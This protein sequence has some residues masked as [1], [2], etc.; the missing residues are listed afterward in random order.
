[1]KNTL[2]R[3]LF[4]ALIVVFG[5]FVC[6][7]GIQLELFSGAGVDPLTMFEEGLGRTIS[8][9]TGTVTL[10]VNIAMLLLALVLNRRNIWIGSAITV[11]LLGPSIN[12]FAGIMAELGMVPPA[13]WAGKI[14][15]N[16]AGVF[17][18]GLGIAIYML[19]DYGVGAMEAVMIFLS[20]K[21]HIPYGPTRIAMD[22]TWGVI[23]FFLGG[24]LG[25]GT[26]IG[27]FGIGASLDL[28]F[29]LMKKWWG[30][31]IPQGK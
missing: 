3:Q 25:V 20:Q 6:G 19:P 28:S 10:G 14:A 26:V 13:G 18:T 11:F 15:M 9:Q 29:R 16:V 22:C 17:L 8:V 21:L 7:L 24:T 31:K 5:T 4:Q 27:A 30:D 12:I 2:G 1:M 23:G